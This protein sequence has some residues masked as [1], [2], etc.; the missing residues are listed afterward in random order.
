MKS[1]S[2][3]SVQSSVK[4]RCLHKKVWIFYKKRH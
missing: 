2:Q 3:Q 1:P 4:I